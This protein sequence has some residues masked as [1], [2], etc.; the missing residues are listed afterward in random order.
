MKVIVASTIVPFLQGGGTA[1]VDDLERALKGRGH[2][3]DTVLLPFWS[4]PLQMLQQMLALR[5]LDVSH[6]GDLLIAIRTPSYILRHPHK[7]I[8]FIHHHRPAYDLVGTEF[9]QAR[10]PELERIRESIV[11]ADNVFLREAERVYTNSRVV[12]ERLRRFNRLE[13]EVLYPPLGDASG[14]RCE[15]YGDYVFYPS[16][17]S[18]GKRQSLMIEA[19]AHVRSPARLV[20][21]GRPDVDSHRE[22]LRATIERCG[23]EDKV[24]LRAGWMSEEE[25]REL[26]ARA[27]ASAY[28]PYDEDSYGYVSLES[29]HSGKPVITCSDSGGTLELVEDGVNGVVVPPEPEALAEAIDSL[30]ED[31]ERAQEM[32][33]VGRAKLDSL[34]ISW[35]TVVETLTG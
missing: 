3:V 27:L 23:V 11:E 4:D 15:A 1:I 24:D 13:S 10:T 2:E 8:W 7:V 21:A 31:K 14:Y 35:D 33:E 29:Y 34:R 30:Y 12:G 19:M 32:G 28:V 6:E 9:E 22:S 17:L 5:L 26:F 18:A 16:R 20:L 25:K